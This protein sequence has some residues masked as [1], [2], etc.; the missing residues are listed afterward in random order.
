MD[1][2]SWKALRTTCHILSSSTGVG[3]CQYTGP[4]VEHCD[5][6]LQRVAA[7]NGHVDVFLKVE[8]A[9]AQAVAQILRPCGHWNTWV[10]VSW[11]LWH[12]GHLWS[13]A[14]SILCQ[15]DMVAN[16]ANSSLKIV[17]CW[18]GDEWR[19]VQ[20]LAFQSIKWKIMGSCHPA[21]CMTYLINSDRKLAS[22]IAEAVWA[23]IN[24]PLISREAMCP[25]G[26]I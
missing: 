5:I 20:A 12:L 9:L 23:V 17:R 14:F 25:V 7:M 10:S 11:N 21:L 22:L 18:L 8:V 13:I 2:C 3:P 1:C 24:M 4:P 16:S 26:R 19:L 6:P 15:Q